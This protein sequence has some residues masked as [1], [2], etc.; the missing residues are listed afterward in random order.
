MAE[1]FP[2]ERRQTAVWPDFAKFRHFGTTYYDFGNILTVYLVFGKSMNI[3]C[4]KNYAIRQ[5]F[6]V[7]KSQ[8]F[9]SY[10]AMNNRKHLKTL[11]AHIFES[12]IYWSWAVWPDWAIY[13]TLGNFLKPLAIIDLPKSPTFFG[14]FCKGVKI[15]NFSCEIIFRQLW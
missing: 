9:N 14:N 4:P 3:F 8:I 6:I 1:I 11:I 10:L 15:F 5:F 2:S 13:W 12:G 7:V